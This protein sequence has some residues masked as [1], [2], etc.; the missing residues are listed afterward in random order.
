MKGHGGPVTFLY[1]SETQNHNRMKHLLLVA[2]MAS[3]TIAL[4]QPKAAKWDVTN[5]TGQFNYKDVPL[6]T[7]EGTWMNLDVSPDGKQIVFDLLGDIYIMPATGGEAKAL[8]SGVPFEIQPKFS[9]NGKQISFTSDAGGGDNIWVMNIDGTQARQVT[10][11]DFRLLN[12]ASWTPDGNYLIARKHF[13][14]QRSLGAGEMWMYHVSGGT[15]IQLT[16]R[17]NDQQD[18]NEPTV[19]PDGRYVYFCEDMYP[20]GYFQYNKNPNEQIYVTRRYDL[21][22]GE[23]VDIT[24]GPGGA[25]RPQ[26]SRDGKK[27]AFVR[28]VREKTVLFVHDLASGE[29]RPVYDDLSKDQSEAWAILGIYPNY[30]WTPDQSAIII[31]AKGKIRRVDLTTLAVTTLPFKVTNQLKVAE[32]LHFRNQA[33]SE[34]FTSKSIR[35][36]VTSPDGKWLVFNA[37]GYLWKKELPGG[38]P[39]RVTSGTDF[40]FEPAFSPNGAEVVYVTWND[41]QRGAIMK[42]NLTVKGAKPVK[43]TSE[44]GNY[45]QP[46]F[47]PDGSRIVFVKEDGNDHQGYTYGKDPGLYWIASS[48]GA[49]TLIKGEG[50]YPQFS[51]DGKRIVYQ[52]GGG[53]KS[54]KSVKLDGTDERVLATLRSAFRL[55]PSPDEQW[56]AFA[57]AYKVYIAALPQAGKPVELDGRGESVPSSQVGRDAGINIH[58][59]ADSKKVHWTLGDEY[60]TDELRERFRFLDG[61]PSTLPPMDSVGVKI[62]L[63]LKSDVPDG[64]V[65]FQGARLVTLEGSTVIEDGVIVIHRNRIEA[66]GKRGEVTLPAG[67]KV[68]DAAGKTIVPGF[69]DSHAHIGNFRYGVSP[70]KHWQYYA[71]LAYGVTSSHDPSSNSEM[72]FSQSEMVKTGAMVGPRIF[73]TGTILYGAEGLARTTVNNLDDARSAIRRTKAYGAFSVKSYNQPRRDQRQQIIQAARELNV[74][75]VPEG[76]SN[77]FMNMSMVMDGHT[78]IEHNVPVVP[79]YQD[80]ITLW[81]NSGTAYTPT[82]IVNF[83]GMSGEYYWYQ[84]GNIWE[85]ERL[86]AFTPRSIIDSRSRHRTMIPE[87]EYEIGHIATAQSCKK[88]SDA[89]VK[90]NVGAHGQIQGLGVHW[91]MWMLAQGGMTPMEALRAATLNGASLLGMDTEIGSLKAGKLADLVVLDKN[92]LEDIQN[93]NSVSY[94][95]INGRLYDAATMNET[96]NYNRPR[97]KFFWEQ[98]GYSPAF[99][100]HEE[101]VG[102][103]C[104]RN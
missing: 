69:V 28:R 22:T 91:E 7:D 46:S 13:T 59:S 103:S 33:F 43:V 104:G 64:R 95:M 81:S 85:N 11:E 99:N 15:G 45:R 96:G 8:R 19:S 12:N 86:L 2:L 55:V 83:G 6:S 56:V 30:A 25:A 49:S 63:T 76:G 101:T 51:R 18:V 62:G 26:I 40:E 1:F 29:E 92:P 5:P 36:A 88:L 47:S 61:A 23:L 3:F 32:A 37:A 54:L 65:A 80:V 102:C 35:H 10:K 82:L 14:S 39:T 66:I 17:R 73:S 53:T 16:K 74:E 84:H 94:T 67:T 27:L 21:V 77:F 44:K 38:T 70:Q 79:L 68:I 42:F 57:Q 90:V 75:V 97:S 41:E 4:S 9:P 58:W 52:T 78:S 50:D 20:G 100:W 48:G 72:I 89:G 60:F 34:T 98:N 87:K 71:N 93:T 31:W 24:G